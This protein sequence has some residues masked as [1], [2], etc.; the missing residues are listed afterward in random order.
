MKLYIGSLLCV[1]LAA[2]SHDRPSQ[3]AYESDTHQASTVRDPSMTPASAENAPSRTNDATS[4]VSAR[5]SASLP[6]NATSAPNAPPPGAAPA[7]SGSEASAANSDARDSKAAADSKAAPAAPP[8]N[9]KVNERDRNDQTL[10]PMDQKNN[11][12]DLKITQQI[13]KAVMG[14]NSL[15]FTAKN[16][17]IITI[18]GKVTL[19]GPVKTAQE[20]TAIE[21]AA[22]KVAG[23]TQVDNQIEVKE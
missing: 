23:V 7:R 18:G 8:D 10:T 12:T 6:P 20:R 3:T 21:D 15:S 1:S 22:R 17:K 13:R 4:D 11:E 5:D 16:V 2:C 14:N 19:R 9:T